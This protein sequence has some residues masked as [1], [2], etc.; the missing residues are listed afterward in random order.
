[1]LPFHDITSYITSVVFTSF[2]SPHST[3][4]TAH[5]A[6][7]VGKMSTVPSTTWAATRSAGAWNRSRRKGALPIR[8]HHFIYI[9]FFYDHRAKRRPHGE[10]LLTLSAT[11]STH[12]SA[13]I[14]L[15]LFTTGPG[16]LSCFHL[17]IGLPRGLHPHPTNCDNWH[18]IR[19]KWSGRQTC[20]SKYM[21]AQTVFDVGLLLLRCTP[22]PDRD[23][24]RCD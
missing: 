11:S 17:F 8:T 21:S 4:S 2:T 12:P 1:M 7:V 15:F 3:P 22:G 23:D 9:F 10:L 16:E 13:H 24:D 6:R 18:G 5:H 19:N 14:I 20:M